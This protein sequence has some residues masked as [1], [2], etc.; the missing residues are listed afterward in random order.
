LAK[1]LAYNAPDRRAARRVLGCG[2]VVYLVRDATIPRVEARIHFRAGAYVDPLGKEGLSA[3]VAAALR[4]GGSKNRAAEDLDRALAAIGAT[5]EIQ[6]GETEGEVILRAEPAEFHAALVL[7]LEL[8]R[9]PVFAPKGVEAAKQRMLASLGARDDSVDAIEGRAWRRLVRG[10]H[11]S[12]RLPSAESLAAIT[13]EDLAAYADQFLFPRNFLIAL[14]GAFDET[15]VVP[16]LEEA[17]ASFRN[18]DAPLPVPA[19]PE[20]PAA[21]GVYLVDAGR[22]MATARVRVGF[23]GFKRDNPDRV[24][25]HV[26]LEYLGSELA[27]SRLDRVLRIERGLSWHP[28][29]EL[30]GGDFFNGEP[31]LRA[32]TLAADSPAAAKAILDELRTLGEKPI[33]EDALAAIR[34]SLVDRAAAIETS[35]SARAARF[36]KD[37]LARADAEEI[38]HDRAKLE[39]LTPDECLR[40]ARRWLDPNKAIILIVG[41]GASLDRAEPALAPLGKVNKMPRP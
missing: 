36:A 37:E 25:V 9:E 26:L 6:I 3:I 24:A 22:P 17:F 27:A 1:P 21:P 18:K 20:A 12:T 14:S 33:A 38:S 29:A 41:D 30:A 5:L 15:N 35:A 4:N 32:P 8:L 7:V 13:R 11:F 39:A 40:A 34:Q 31:W 10:N 28:T 16:M 23:V 19:E 2:A